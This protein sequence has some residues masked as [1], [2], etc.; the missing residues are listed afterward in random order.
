MVE[1]YLSVRGKLENYSRG[2]DN[3]KL[4]WLINV[5]AFMFRKVEMIICNFQKGEIIYF[6]GLEGTDELPHPNLFVGEQP[7]L[8]EV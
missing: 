5:S 1:L 2:I 4:E 3:G 6:W 7:W 8:K